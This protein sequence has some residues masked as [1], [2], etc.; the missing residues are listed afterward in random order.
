MGKPSF[1]ILL[2]SPKAYSDYSI[3]QKRIIPPNIKIDNISHG[4]NLDPNSITVE[5]VLDKIKQFI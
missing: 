4:S 2:D 1:I 3:N 5:M